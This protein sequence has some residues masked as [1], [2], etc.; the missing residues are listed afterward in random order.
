MRSEAP[1]F[2][3][4]AVATVL[5]YRGLC[6]CGRVRPLWLDGKLTADEKTLQ[7]H[8]ASANAD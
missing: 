6:S 5:D 2:L 7:E 4:Y 8:I 1:P 3:H